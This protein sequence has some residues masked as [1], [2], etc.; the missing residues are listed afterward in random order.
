MRAALALGCDVFDVSIFV[1]KNYFYPDLAKGYQISQ[2][3]RP[4][5]SKGAVHVGTRDERRSISL[6]RLHMEED[7]GKL[8][9][10]RLP[11]QT[12][13][14]FN[15]AGVPLIEIVTEP[16]IRS[17]KEARQY[18][19]TLKRVLEYLEV[20]DCNMEEGSLRVDAN[21]SVRRPNQPLGIKQEVK[22]MNSFAAAERALEEL[23][24]RQIAAL[25]SGADVELTTYT[26]GDGELRPMRTKEKSHDYRYFPEPDL[27]PI[28]LADLE[29]DVERIRNDLPE[30]PEQKRERFTEQYGL[31]EYQAD[32][33]AATRALG[34]HF[35]GVAALSDDAGKAANWIMGPVLADANE[36]G[37]RYRVA[38][39]RIAQLITLVDSGAVSNQAAKRVFGAIADRDDDPRAVA[40]RLGLVQVSAVAD[41]T[42]WIDVV[43]EAHPDEAARYRA[44]EEKVFG[45]L[46]GQ[47]MKTSGGKADPK[48]VQKLLKNRLG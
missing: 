16:A 4:L 29:L 43:V 34:D 17:P 14:D 20:S 5:A 8:L 15:R 1:R 3:E 27:P 2:F 9:H 47:V 37:G 30:L 7:A 48:Q 11:E 40:E 38:P 32:V 22:N 31:S 10:A 46:M 26:A 44:G 39:N 23:Q 36:H 33:L 18:L 21:L 24:R 41:L 25:D 12:G 28:V 35:E 19:G 42:T 45:F 6:T 13:I